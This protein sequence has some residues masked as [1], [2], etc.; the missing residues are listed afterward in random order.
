MAKRI[1]QASRVIHAP[2][3]IIYQAFAEAKAMETWLPP[4]G[5]TGHMLAFDFREGG[6]Y[7]MRLT[8]NDPRNAPGKSSEESDEVEVR[9]LTLVAD[10]RIEQGVTFASDNPDFS[11]VMTIT[12]TFSAAPQGTEV[13]VRCE[14]VPAGIRPEDH[15]AGLSSTLENLAAFTE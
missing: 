14:D 12:W 10:K 11:G 5:M 1:D 4:K 8:Y 6:F 3:S 13:T 15:E 9:F 2:P 7:R